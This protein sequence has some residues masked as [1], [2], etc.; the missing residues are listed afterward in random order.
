MTGRC[1]CGHAITYAYQLVNSKTA[2]TA[3][4]GSTCIEHFKE[5]ILALYEQLRA[6]RKSR[7]PNKRARTA[8]H[9][10]RR[11]AVELVEDCP[12]QFLLSF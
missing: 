7:K 2:A 5:Y 8:A 9:V 10:A 6:T 11:A 1:V 3:Q 4:V 12:E